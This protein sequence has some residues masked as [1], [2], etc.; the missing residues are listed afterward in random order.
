MSMSCFTKSYRAEEEAWQCVTAHQR[1]PSALE[2]GD[3]TMAWPLT[4]NSASWESMEGLHWFLDLKTEVGFQGLLSKTIKFKVNL[5]Q[6][7]LAHQ[8]VY[9]WTDHCPGVVKGSWYQ[10]FFYQLPQRYESIAVHC[11]HY[12]RFSVCVTVCTC[13]FTGVSTLL[14]PWFQRNHWIL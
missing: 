5:T 12:I 6:P 9:C 1:W 3:L 13:C 2:T 14:I 7:L 4:D 11:Y 8:I 10:H